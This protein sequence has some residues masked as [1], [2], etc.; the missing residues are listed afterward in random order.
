MNNSYLDSILQKMVNPQETGLGGTPSL[1]RSAW[2]G[3]EMDTG[4]LNRLLSFFF[5]GGPRILHGEL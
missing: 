5:L 3:Q 4:E 2:R 1:S